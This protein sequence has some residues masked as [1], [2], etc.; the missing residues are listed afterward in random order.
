MDY[1]HTCFRLHGL[2]IYRTYDILV[3]VPV[4]IHLL[5]VNV[6]LGI[7]GICLATGDGGVHHLSQNLPQGIHVDHNTIF[8]NTRLG[9][10]S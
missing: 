4:V 10:I 1:L 2:P 9:H 7:L 3:D 6:F 8:H 5:D